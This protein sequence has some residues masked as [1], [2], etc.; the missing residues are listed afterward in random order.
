LP[1]LVDWQDGQSR[2]NRS[3]FPA[4]RPTRQQVHVRQELGRTRA[5]V[6]FCPPERQD[7]SDRRAL[8]PQGV[9]HGGQC[10]RRSRSPRPDV[11]QV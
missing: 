11:K 4:R 10:G 7:R 2:G 8:P 3:P 5:S 6:P 1:A 9:L